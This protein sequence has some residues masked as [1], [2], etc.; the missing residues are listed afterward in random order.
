MDE[1]TRERL[2]AQEAAQRESQQPP[3]PEPVE[4]GDLDDEVLEDE[5]ISLNGDD[6]A[7]GVNVESILQ[8]AQEERD[9]KLR[10]LTL[11]LDIPSW[12]GVFVAEYKLLPRNL[13]ES[14]QQRSR[15]KKDI[16]SEMDMIARACV[17]IWVRDPDSGRLIELD[18]DK[19][20]RYTVDL[21]KVLGKTKLLEGKKSEKE[22]YIT[23]RH[24]FAG[25]ELS[26]GAHA[27][28]LITWMA[29][30]TSYTGEE[31]DDDEDS[32]D[33]PGEA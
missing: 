11:K 4:P 25:N 19:P 20:V 29:D 9:E 3:P 15:S 28:Q 23:I 24:M 2:R 10:Q 27:F 12:D 31:E 1:Q 21:L 6:T 22:P 17:N 18:E 13:V 30:P 26:I 5:D 14:M 33:G 32:G 7:L 16:N 8:R